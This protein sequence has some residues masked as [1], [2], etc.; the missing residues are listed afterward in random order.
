MKNLNPQL[1]GENQE[2]APEIEWLL[3]SRQFSADQVAEEL[4]KFCFT[5]LYRWMLLC[6]DERETAAAAAI[7]TILTAAENAYRYPSE[8][9]R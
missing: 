4:V 2:L 9:G 5:D 8:P 7:Q 1:P 3:Q 6:L